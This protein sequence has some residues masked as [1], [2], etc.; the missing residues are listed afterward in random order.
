MDG[1]L[2]AQFEASALFL[3]NEMK[4]I[5]VSGKTTGKHG[6]VTNV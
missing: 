6:M 5:S 3:G 2:A 4:Q 1:E